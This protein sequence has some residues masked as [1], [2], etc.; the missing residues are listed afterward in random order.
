[1]SHSIIFPWVDT[2]DCLSRQAEVTAL[3]RPPFCSLQF[4]R[5]ESIRI[6]KIKKK[7]KIEKKMRASR[8]ANG[9]FGMIFDGML[10]SAGVSGV[11]RV[12][13][14]NLYSEMVVPNVKNLPAR[15]AI[16]AYLN[17]GEWVVDS[18]IQVW[19]NARGNSDRD[20]YEP[21]QPRTGENSRIDDQRGTSRG[22]R[23]R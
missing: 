9:L 15:S 7:K 19:D 13:G 16:R 10:V 18:G 4:P 6:L 17:A 2:V 3:L 1:V 21:P 11:R 23:H 5:I 12:T 8:Q 20:T 22:F 14:Y